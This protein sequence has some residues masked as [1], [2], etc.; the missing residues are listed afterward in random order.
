METVLVSPFD[1][2]FRNFFDSRSNFNLLD[3]VKIPH[4]VNILETKDGLVFEIACTGLSKDQVEINIEHDVLRVSH[5]KEAA[6]PSEYEG[7]NYLVR[8]ITKKA[9][10]LG[11]KVAS[12]FN[13]KEADAKMENGLLIITVPFAPEAQP[14]TLRIK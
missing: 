10:N 1:I 2:L 5:N 13:L 14:K 9:F 11:Y 12:R 3:D 7:R 8:G 6:D 4:P